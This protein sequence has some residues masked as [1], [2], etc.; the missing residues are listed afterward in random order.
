ML[1]RTTSEDV[2]TATAF[3][4]LRNLTPAKWLGYW[5]N[6]SFETD[7]FTGAAFDE[8]RFQ[9]WPSLSPP[10]GLRYREGAS[11]PDLII[12]FDDVVV[13]VEAKYTASLSSGTTHNGNRNQLIR[14]L[15]ALYHHY[16]GSSLF[17][18]RC[19]L[20]T[21]TLEV[22]DLVKRYRSRENVVQDLMQ[23]DCS[24]SA[25][26]EMAASVTVGA[27]TWNSLSS[28]LAYRLEAF[29]DNP[30]E[31]AFALDVITYLA[32]KVAQVQAA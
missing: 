22:P 30:V 2:V 3:G 10:P 24:R 16:G 14:F 11:K 23:F 25:A 31:E 27:S 21:L 13:L 12:R 26:E 8:L 7:A 20:M 15:D 32:V 18:K 5:L 1:L 17:T 29:G 19:Y 6:Q 9:L 28:I 4:I